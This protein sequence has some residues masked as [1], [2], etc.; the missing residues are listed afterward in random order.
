MINGKKGFSRAR[1][2][3]STSSN[4][5]LL[6]QLALTNFNNGYHWQKEYY[7]IILLYYT[8]FVSASGN[9]IIEIKENPIFQK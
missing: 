9:Y 2:T 7:T 6:E 1:K 8:T 5:V 3:I 4:E